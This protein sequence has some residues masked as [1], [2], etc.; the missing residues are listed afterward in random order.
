MLVPGVPCNLSLTFMRKMRLTIPLSPIFAFNSVYVLP[1]QNETFFF[2]LFTSPKKSPFLVKSYKVNKLSHSAATWKK[3]V[4][5]WRRALAEWRQRGFL[6]SLI[7][8]GE[9]SNYIMDYLK[10]AQGSSTSGGERLRFSLFRWKAQ[11]N[12][13]LFP[14]NKHSRSQNHIFSS[15]PNFYN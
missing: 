9:G 5:F 2:V 13:H 14:V 1:S 7:P 12:W 4:A 15:N 8:L 6:I 3:S 11:F 10:Q